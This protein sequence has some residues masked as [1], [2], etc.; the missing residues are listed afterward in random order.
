MFDLLAR[1]VA[2]GTLA[3]SQGGYT[4]DGTK[5]DKGHAFAIIARRWVT[6][7]DGAFQASESGR[8]VAQARGVIA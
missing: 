3:Y 6:F 8:K 2:G 7:G 5:V 1:I 4:L